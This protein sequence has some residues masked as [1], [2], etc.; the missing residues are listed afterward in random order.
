MDEVRIVRDAYP[1]PAPPTAQEIAR[2]KALLEAPPRRPL[3]RRLRWGLGGVVA[4]GTAATVAIALAGGNAP[5]PT[6]P[7]TLDGRAAVLAAAEK[8]ERQ[9]TGDY[10]HS[11]VIQG[12]AYVVRAKTGTYAITGALTQ[13]FGWWG[14]K[15]GMGEGYYGRDLPARPQ[16]ARDEALWRR[17]GSPSTFRVWSGDHY[18]TYTTKPTK[19]QKDGPEKGTDPRGGGRFLDGKSVEELQQLPTEPAKLAEMFLNGSGTLAEG[20]PSGGDRR[21][22][23]GAQVMRVASILGGAPIPPKVRAG[24]MRALADRPGVHAIGRTTDPLGRPGIALATDDRATTV[25]GEYG[26]PKTDQGTYR[27]REVIV[28]DEHTGALLSRQNELT[29]P[30]GR[31]AEMQPGFVIEY[32]AVRSAEWTDTRPEPSPELPFD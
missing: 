10:W 21:A 9:P 2:A 29:E 7:V 23:S 28:F 14:A 5:A 31:Y 24:L 26:G 32:S 19:W 27:S 17:A 22:S 18:N 11:N 30:G 6:G 16:T 3:P 8:A 15:S 13:S 25:R 4:A 1:E 12:Q 20:D